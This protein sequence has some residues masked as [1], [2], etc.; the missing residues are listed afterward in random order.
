M[1]HVPGDGAAREGEGLS[2]LL[3]RVHEELRRLAAARLRHQ[4]GNHT[5]QPTAL[6]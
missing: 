3:P 1:D 2:D 5:L 4:P 6:V